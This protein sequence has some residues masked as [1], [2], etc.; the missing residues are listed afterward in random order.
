MGLFA[1]G[2]DGNLSWPFLTNGL[3]SL[4]IFNPFRASYSLGPSLPSGRWY[5]SLLTLAD[6]TILIMGGAKVTVANDASCLLG[7]LP[8]RPEPC[9]EVIT[10][11]HHNADSRGRPIHLADLMEDHAL[12]D[13]QMAVCKA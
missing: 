1:G 8:C 5:P 12:R 4:R 6:G 11:A 3:A 7:H 9:H 13:V 2:D 10:Q